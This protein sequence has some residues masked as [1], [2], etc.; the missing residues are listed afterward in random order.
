MRTKLAVSAAI[1]MAACFS[2]NASEATARAQQ[3]QAQPDQ[4]L[5]FASTGRTYAVEPNLIAVR[6]RSHRDADLIQAALPQGATRRQHH[7]PGWSLID[8]NQATQPNAARLDFNAS[9]ARNAPDLYTARIAR[10][11][12][13]GPLTVHPEIVV[14]FS[15]HLSDNETV[16]F[17]NQ[18]NLG[19]AEEHNYAGIPNATR[20]MT[21]ATN[22]DAVLDIANSLNNHPAVQYAEPIVSFT[23][24]STS[25]NITEPAFD[26]LWAHQNTG[27]QG[28]TEDADMDTPEAWAI[29]AGDPSVI[30]VVIDT[31][32]QLNHPDI[33]VIGGADFT[34]DPAT[35]GGPFNP[36]DNHGTAVASCIAAPINGRGTIGS[37]PNTSVA[38][39]R[40]FISVTSGGVWVSSTD[41]TV[42]ALDWAYSIGARITNNSNAYGFT[43]A[44]I[45][46]KYQQTADL[47]MLHF[48]SAGN[49]NVNL[50]S[51][52]SSID[53]VTAVSALSPDNT[54]APF[55]NRGNKLF[56]SAP[57]VDIL[58]ADRTGSAGYQN[59]ETT[60]L[61]GTS[62]SSPFV[63]GVAALG[64]S[65]APQASRQAILDRLAS[66]AT[67]ID[68]PG[69]DKRTGHGHVNA[70]R[71]VAAVSCPTDL[72]DSGVTDI[73][74]LVT[75][76]AEF[77]SGE[78]DTNLNGLGGEL[79]DL[80]AVLS[81]IG[82][83]C[84]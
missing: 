10:D 72:N 48:A 63:A 83:N 40:T 36:Y 24:Q 50:L 74:D 23:G 43:S 65:I 37:A 14:A 20:F 49:M 44:L 58:T 47:G 70:A 66:T 81:A 32:V 42:Q 33:N 45:D 21:S 7:L 27:Q 28:G 29:E 69:W 12:L 55:S 18:H 46:D 8:F 64:L 9:I 71:F 17:A 80:L 57:G 78:P 35:S 13:G 56:I 51:Y 75:I 15:R 11:D 60:T 26:L 61:S 76:L 41:W 19:N 1:L 3:A 59:G 79:N 30:T 84:R 4:A 73:D 2:T 16:N 5:R 53:A 52:P 25:V 68:D 54:L 22:A 38:S 77:G 34:S 39:A 67:D 6:H 62:F 82:Q 31:G